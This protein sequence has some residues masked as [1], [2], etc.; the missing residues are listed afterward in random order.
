M[1]GGE[2]GGVVEG[3]R[4]FGG[5]GG[6]VGDGGGGGG[7]LFLGMVFCCLLELRIEI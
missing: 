1:L 7:V 6:G 4:H 3:E 2:D 5:F